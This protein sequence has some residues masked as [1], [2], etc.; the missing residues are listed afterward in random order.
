MVLRA[1]GAGN[2]GDNRL[3]LG[4]TLKVY[5]PLRAPSRVYYI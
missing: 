2:L 1:G 4:M 3:L 5:L